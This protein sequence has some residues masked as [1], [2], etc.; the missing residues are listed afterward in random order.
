[1]M[2][3]MFIPE[4]VIVKPSKRYHHILSEVEYFNVDRQKL[5]GL[6]CPNCGEHELYRGGV[7]IGCT[8]CFCYFAELD[9]INA[10]LED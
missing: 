2:F 3:A 4:E 5:L 10:N 8:G 6:K 7:Y 9:I 1:M